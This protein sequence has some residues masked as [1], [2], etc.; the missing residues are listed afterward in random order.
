MASNTHSKSVA[1]VVALA[2]AVAV[3]LNINIFFV[4]NMESQCDRIETRNGDEAATREFVC[5]AYKNRTI[6][7][8]PTKT[9]LLFWCFSWHFPL[10][11]MEVPF[12]L[13]D[14]F[15]I[16]FISLLLLHTHTNTVTPN[17]MG[18]KWGENR[19]INV[20]ILNWH[21]LAAIVDII[22]ISRT[23]KRKGNIDFRKSSF[24]VRICEL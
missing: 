13:F 6:N 11:L 12:L 4:R 24:T 3:I 22:I 14:F 16:F 2:V 10:I 1:I 15:F 23:K 7:A 8:G 20:V 19:F 5:M 9:R 21:Y 17:Y 18:K